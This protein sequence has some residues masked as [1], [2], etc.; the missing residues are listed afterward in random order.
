MS[1]IIEIDKIKSL[2]D[3]TTSIQITKSDGVTPSLVVDSVND[4]VGIN[5]IPIYPIHVDANKPNNDDNFIVIGGSEDY[6]RGFEI[7]INDIPKWTQYIYDGEDGDTQ[8]FASENSKRDI[9][10]LQSG[11][12]VGIN[13]PT[14]VSNIQ[15]LRI[16]QTGTNTYATVTCENPHKLSNNQP[17]EI[18][19]AT[20]SK[21]NGQ[22]T[23]NSV[24]T[25]T[26]R[27]T[28]LDVGAIT[29]DPTDANIITTTNI[30]AAFTVYPQYFDSIYSFNESLNVGVGTGFVNLTTNMKTSFGT[31]DIIL[32]TTTGSYLYLGK[33]YPWRATAFNITTASVGASAI[34][35]EYYNT[36]GTWTTL[37]T[38][39]TSGNN[40]VD[41]TSRLRNDGSISWNLA[42]FKHL[43]GHT[44]LQVNP[45]PMFTQDLYWIRVSLTGTITTSPTAQSISNHGID[46]MSLFAQAGDVNPFFKLDMLGRV[47]FL[48]PELDTDYKLGTL[49]GLTTSKFEVV[50][51]DG[52]RSDFVYYLANDNTLQHPA[53]LMTRSAGSV[54]IKSAVTNGMDLGGLY[55]MGYDGSTFRECAKMMSETVST[56]TANSLTGILD[57]YTRSEQDES[58]KLRMRIDKQGKIGMGVTPAHGALD[59]AG[60]FAFR[61]LPT[62]SRPLPSTPSVGGSIDLGTHSWKVTCSSAAGET[63][64]STASSTITVTTG[65]QTVV[66]TIP[67]GAA[68]TISRKIYRTV[69]G[70]TGN[71]K[72]VGTIL[73]NTTT[74]FTDTF[75]D[76]TLGADA[77]ST[78]TSLIGN[79][80][81]GSVNVMSMTSGGSIGI[82]N[83]IPDVALDVNGFTQLGIDSPKIKMLKLTGTTNSSEGGSTTVAHGLTGDKIISLN[84]KVI[85]STNNGI[86]PCST[87]TGNRFE[88]NHD[89]TNVNVVNDATNSENILSKT[90][91]ITIIYEE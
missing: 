80:N 40:L 69:A 71:W 39:A 37:T 24:T 44:K 73:N 17:I 62:P 29:E 76:S 21:F 65:N 27:I 12:R 77:P 8:Y 38:S 45:A 41:G 15:I 91:I 61:E 47:G 42:T 51:E 35:V 46:R 53:I 16:V 87:S 14:F 88:C 5:R 63:I 32:P 84:C 86:L 56:A 1:K 30:P 89:S 19:D 72:L 2:I 28:G 66:L 4:N 13:I 90:F 26:F 34:V 25:M 22:F 82:G 33:M 52:R 57:F 48:P 64:P 70:N 7:D 85:S 36:V 58:T 18:K 10:C 68:G 78:N 20:T 60:A 43:W 83:N 11:G 49:G 79:I 74:T 31:P 50:S 9:L 75:A 81:V 59:L 6:T 3:S 67:V 55:F 54:S 23:V